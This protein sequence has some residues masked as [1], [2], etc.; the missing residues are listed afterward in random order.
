MNTSFKFDESNKIF[1]RNSQKIING[2]KCASLTLFYILHEIIGYG[3]AEAIQQHYGSLLQKESKLWKLTVDFFRKI[4]TQMY[5]P[6]VYLNALIRPE[7]MKCL[8][9]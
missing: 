4:P 6:Q 3:G 8:V 7:K 9:R 1:I 5:S 2:S